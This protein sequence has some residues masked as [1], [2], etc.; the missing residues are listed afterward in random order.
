MSPENL[1]VHDGNVYIIDLGM[2]LRVPAMDGGGVD[3]TAKQQQKRQRAL[4]TPQTPCGKWYYLS[5]EVLLSEQ[6]F[7]GPTVDLWATGVILFIMLTGL[8]PWEEPKMTDEN[9]K[10]MSTGYLMQILTER[11]VGLSADAMDLLQRMFW[12]DPADRLSLEQV[13]AHPWMTHRENLPFNGHDNRA[14]IST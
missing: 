11:R 12:L 13:C 6:P 7:D 1:M 3:V 5:P 9:F 10:L 4:I 14:T 2:C 8:P